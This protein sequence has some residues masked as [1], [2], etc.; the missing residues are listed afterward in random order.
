LQTLALLHAPGLNVNI[1]LVH[2][3]KIFS[4]GR[5]EREQCLLQLP[6]CDVVG[7]LFV[8]TTGFEPAL[9]TDFL[10]RRRERLIERRIILYVNHLV[11]QFVE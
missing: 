11:S 4:G 5:N 8:F 10:D 3:V 2:A 7:H 1:G 9:H 6:A